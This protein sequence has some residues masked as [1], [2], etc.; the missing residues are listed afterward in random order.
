MMCVEKRRLVLCLF[1]WFIG[2]FM[3]HLV[4]YSASDLKCPCDEKSLI[5]FETH[6]NNISRRVLAVFSVSRYLFSF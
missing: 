6:Q 3:R 4:Y 2:C 1:I 5:Q